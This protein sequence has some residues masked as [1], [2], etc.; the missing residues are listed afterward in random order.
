M[1][2]IFQLFYIVIFS[3][4]IVFQG[5]KKEDEPNRFPLAKEHNVDETMLVRAFDKMKNVEGALSLIVCRDGV[6]VAEEYYNYNNY[7]KDSIKSVLSVTK[8]F[9]GLL[10][11]IAID[12]GYIESVNDSISKYLAGLV[13]FPDSV[14][15]NITIDQLLKMSV[16]HE[17][18]GTGPAS[19][20][21]DW[22]NSADEIQYVI[23][24]P[25]T[26]TPGTVFNYSDGASH[27]L[28]AIINQTTGKNTMDFAKQYLFDPLGYTRFEWTTDERGIPNGAAGLRI[29]PGDM[30][31]FGNLILSNGKYNGSQIVS[32]TWINTMTTTKISTNNNVIYGPEYGYQIWLGTSGGRKHIMA[33][34]W[35]GQFIFIVPDKNLVVTATCWHSGLDWPEAGE[36]W[37]SIV[38]II[39]NDIFP[40]VK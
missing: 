22:T 14:K 27:L 32:E 4:F 9:V 8:S 6:I 16:G 34:G 19:L 31:K 36:H 15:A 30:V 25:L 1:R 3:I 28:S 7:G 38:N 12:K 23:D 17:W 20:Y 29:K 26:S 33:M 35:G 39:V 40:A 10:V 24:L 5:C 18:N 37:T 21:S 11:G 2:K 13:T